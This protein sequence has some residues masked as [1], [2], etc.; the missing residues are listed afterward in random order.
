MSKGNSTK[1]PPWAY[2]YIRFSD[3]KQGEGDSVRRQTADALDWCS[4]NG[5]SLD[6]TTTLHDLGTSAFRGDHRKNPDRNAL[7]DD[8]IDFDGCSCAA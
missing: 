7:V 6:T 3:P 2:S 4:A 8:A 1:A 5:A